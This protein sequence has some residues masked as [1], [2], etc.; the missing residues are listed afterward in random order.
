MKKEFFKR[1]YRNVPYFSDNPTQ[2]RKKIVD[3]VYRGIK[4]KTEVY[5]V[6]PIPKRKMTDDTSSSP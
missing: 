3:I 6:N 1:V 4:G 2:R 5:E